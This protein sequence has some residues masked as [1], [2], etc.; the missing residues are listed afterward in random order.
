M[1]ARSLIAEQK[2][3]LSRADVEA[4]QRVVTGLEKAWNNA[5][6]EDY[7]LWF[8]GDAEFVNV[9][10][11]YAQGRGGN[12]PVRDKK[13]LVAELRQAVADATA[14]CKASISAAYSATLLSWLPIH[15]A[16]RTGP[17]ATPLITT[18]MPDGPGF[19]KHPPST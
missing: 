15:F 8:Q 12:L 1:A 2:A 5:D 10:A 16:M 17:S 4:I 6:G 13:A 11:I 18:P 9:Y 14:Y 7:G 19:P 3:E